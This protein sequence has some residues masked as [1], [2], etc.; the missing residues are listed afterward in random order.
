MSKHLAEIQAARRKLNEDWHRIQRPKFEQVPVEALSDTRFV[1]NFFWNQC[2]MP[3]LAAP[4]HLLHAGMIDELLPLYALPPSEPEA[5]AEAEA[6]GRR[7][8]ADSFT[9]LSAS[10]AFGGLL[11]QADTETTTLHEPRLSGTVLMGR[12]TETSSL[13]TTSEAAIAEAGL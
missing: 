12:I 10:G 1:P 9:D 7:S 13:D 3:E 5:E 11:R 4:S 8:L 6:N 2:G